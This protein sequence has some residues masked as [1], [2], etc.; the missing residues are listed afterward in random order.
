MALPCAKS[1][2]LPKMENVYYDILYN[3]ANQV[4]TPEP[5]KIID[6]LLKTA[7]LHPL[8]IVIKVLLANGIV[9]AFFID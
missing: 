2:F 9:I 6:H 4:K 7:Y 5:T 8:Y 1:L 3:S